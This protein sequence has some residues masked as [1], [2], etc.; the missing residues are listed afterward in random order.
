MFTSFVVLVVS[1]RRLHGHAAAGA[2]PAG[3]TLAVPALLAHGALAVPVTK[4]RTTV[5]EG[6]DRWTR[7]GREVRNHSGRISVM[8][9]MHRLSLT[10]T[11]VDTA[12]IH[13]VF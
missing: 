10:H 3:L 13:Q 11:H 2:P 7:G 9:V 5:C 1:T 4:V 6:E 8:L 12:I